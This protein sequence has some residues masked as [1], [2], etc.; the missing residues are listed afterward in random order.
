MPSPSPSALALAWNSPAAGT[1]MPALASSTIHTSK[2][3]ARRSRAAKKQQM[4]VAIP[5]TTTA[6]MPLASGSGEGGVLGRD[7]VGLEVAVVALPPDGG[8][9][10]RC[11]SPGRNSAPGVPITQCGG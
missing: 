4:L 1:S 5:H 2:P 11:A 9:A 7:R 6:L 10:V 3:A 8:E